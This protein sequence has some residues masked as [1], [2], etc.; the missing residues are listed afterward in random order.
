MYWNVPHLIF[1]SGTEPQ[2]FYGNV[3]H[4]RRNAAHLLQQNRPQQGGAAAHEGLLDAEQSQTD[5]RPTKFGGSACFRPFLRA[6]DEI[7]S[8]AQAENHR[9]VQDDQLP[10]AKNI[11]VVCAQSYRE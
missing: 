9:S 6:A 5:A 2:F 10:P 3:A 1:N 7:V 4:F 11:H 8:R